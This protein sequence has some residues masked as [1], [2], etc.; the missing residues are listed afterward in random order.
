MNTL[1]GVASRRQQKDLLRQAREQQVAQMKAAQSRRTRLTSL[2]AVL[3]GVIIAAGVFILVS[4][5]GGGGPAS[6]VLTQ[7][8][9][10]GYTH[11]A[12]QADV[13]QLLKGIPQHGNVLGNPN[14]PITITEFGDLA[15]SSCDD[16]ALTSEQQLIADYVRTGKAQIQYRGVE[17]ASGY[18]N[19]GE[20]TAT[21][22]AARAAGLQNME[23]NYLILLY[24]EQPRVIGGKDSELVK[25]ISAAYLLNRAQQL[26]SS[27]LNVG[28]WQKHLSDPTLIQDV[29]ADGAAANA[30][31]VSGTPAIFISGAKG[32]VEYDKG[33]TQPSVVPT[34]QQL[35]A[36]I[37]QVS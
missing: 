12:A 23:W 7:Q 1:R 11:A 13:A 14:A 8:D 19:G 28:E 27:G 37:A 35:Q 36:L 25:Y 9:G 30:Q 6:Q 4:S 3:V 22:V 32:T 15:C 5:S 26:V 2:S 24:D 31:G 34:I 21:Q 20:Y 33:S 16:F 17:T 29:A 18:A 10:A